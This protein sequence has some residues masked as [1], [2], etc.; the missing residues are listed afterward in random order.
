MQ[1]FSVAMHRHSILEKVAERLDM[2]YQPF[3]LPSLPVTHVLPKAHLT[4]I[5]FHSSNEESR[6]AS[7]GFELPGKLQSFGEKADKVRH[8]GFI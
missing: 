7:N 5:E 4:D 6:E 8:Q 1:S 2:I 3:A